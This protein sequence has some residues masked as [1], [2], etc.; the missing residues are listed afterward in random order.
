MLCVSSKELSALWWKSFF[1][2][3][4]KLQWKKHFNTSSPHSNEQSVCTLQALD[5]F[6]QEW[7]MPPES[8]WN[9]VSFY[10][11]KAAI[12]KCCCCGY[13]W[14]DAHDGGLPKD[15]QHRLKLL[16]EEFYL[17]MHCFVDTVF[18][19]WMMYEFGSAF[20]CEGYV[21]SLILAQ[22]LKCPSL[23]RL[24]NLLTFS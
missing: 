11:F 1:A 16:T 4:A 7:Y 9:G 3:L 14:N 15:A 5:H 13:S 24:D 10:T 2:P 12:S 8:E 20:Y 22:T 18:V 17:L 21:F 23:Q 19:F 6:Y